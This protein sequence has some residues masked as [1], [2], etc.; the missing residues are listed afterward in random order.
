MP[1]TMK[2]SCVAHVPI[3]VSAILYTLYQVS[4]SQPRTY[5]PLL[6]VAAIV[7]SAGNTRAREPRAHWQ[8]HGPCKPPNV[9]A[10]RVHTRT[11]DSPW[12]FVVCGA[13]AHSVRT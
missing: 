8:C 3:Q 11:C 4:N 10:A 2:P 1:M 13:W 7:D 5:C 12:P 9:D 6:R